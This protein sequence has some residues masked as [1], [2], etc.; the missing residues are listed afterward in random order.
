MAAKDDIE[1]LQA[2]NDALRARVDELERLQ[3]GEAAAFLQSVLA[4]VP[5]FI[6]RTDA[7]TRIR[8]INRLQPGLTM[9]AVIGRS[10]YDFVAPEY[11]A[12]ARECNDRA[13]ETGIAQQYEVIGDGPHG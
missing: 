4:A 8:Y 11:Q 10:G 2:E 12:I 6:I 13:K 3:G 5:A 7:D 9:E 1:A